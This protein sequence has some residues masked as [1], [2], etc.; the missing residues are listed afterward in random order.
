MA[1]W[2]CSVWGRPAQRDP[3]VELKAS[4]P[5]IKDYSAAR[6]SDSWKNPVASDAHEFVRMLC[7]T[8]DKTREDETRMTPAHQD[9][10]L[11]L[12]RD[13]FSAYDTL[14]SGPVPA[15]LVR[16]YSCVLFLDNVVPEEGLSFDGWQLGE[17]RPTTEEE[18]KTHMLDTMLKLRRAQNTTRVEDPTVE[19]EWEAEAT[20]L[21]GSPA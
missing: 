15:R 9:E 13:F 18:R 4:D 12:F 21:L 3:Y 1:E 19:E 20:D 2:L 5:F 7:A 8:I 14:L 17:D 6:L 11:A 16:F 10:A